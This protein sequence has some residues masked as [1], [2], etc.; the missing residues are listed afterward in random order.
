[1]HSKSFSLVKRNAKSIKTNLMSKIDI[2]REISP[3][4]GRNLG[5]VMHLHPLSSLLHPPVHFR[6]RD[7][8]LRTSAW[9]ARGEA[10]K[11]HGALFCMSVKLV[12]TNVI[13][14]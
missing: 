8:A 5:F 9:E 6:A 12:I 13:R 1:M 14:H 3:P 7:F 11:L 2:L 10:D 4:G